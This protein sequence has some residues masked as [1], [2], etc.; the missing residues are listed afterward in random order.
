MDNNLY[1]FLQSSAGA[2][3]VRGLSLL[4]AL[5]AVGIAI[6]ALRS[7]IRGQKDEGTE[8]GAAPW[9]LLLGTFR[10]TFTIT[11]LYS[12]YYVLDLSSSLKIF[13]PDSASDAAMSTRIGMTLVH[14]ILELAVLFIAAR[15]IASIGRWLSA[16]AKQ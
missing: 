16:R 1:A 9:G 3:T 13:L 8:L 10:D 14:I 7:Y 5:A 2:L 4:L 15:R 11:V 6:F 12:A